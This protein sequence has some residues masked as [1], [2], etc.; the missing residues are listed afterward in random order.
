MSIEKF[1][2]LILL[3]EDFAFHQ[4]FNQFPLLKAGG[5]SRNSD[6]ASSESLFEE[7]LGPIKEAVYLIEV[8]KIKPNPYQPRRN[9]NEDGIK[10]LAESIR[11]YGILQ[12]LVVSK[13]EKETSTGTI[14]EYQLIAGERRLRAAKLLGLERVPAIIR[15]SFEER[16]KLEAAIIE[17][18]QRLELNPLEIARGF[19]KLTEEF[20]FSQREIAQRIGK[21]REF[22]ANTLRLL[23]LPSEAQKA[24]AE[25][26][27]TESHAR[28]ILS[29]QNPEKQRIILG[30][31]LTRKLTVRE[32]EIL[33]RRL[34]G[35]FPEEETSTSLAN[36]GDALVKEIK[37]KL[38]EKL[39]TKVEVRKKGEKGK[40]T[41]NF[42]S[43]EEL[44][45][46]LEKLLQ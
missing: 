23:Q 1:R 40:I 7:D 18:L 19:A 24:L 31:I 15:P 46:I 21:S 41:I 45:Q 26:Q 2:D 4:E 32:T 5:D 43:E 38:E 16:Q 39:G 10:E 14:V 3:M 12:P 29:I 33:A 42:F 27:I 11:A 35:L 30:E 17:N 8:E 6:S 36:L 9:F 37:E 22:I 34:L 28:V 44:N 25:G 13:V 20:G